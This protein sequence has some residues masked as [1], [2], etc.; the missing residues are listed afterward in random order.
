MVK[1]GFKGEKYESIYKRFSLVQNIEFETGKDIIKPNYEQ[2]LIG[3]GISIK[4]LI[5][6]LKSKDYCTSW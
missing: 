2:Y 3:V 1:C 5:S 4:D 6:N